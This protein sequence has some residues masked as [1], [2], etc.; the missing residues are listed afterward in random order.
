MK[1][2]RRLLVAGLLAVVLMVQL[3]VPVM[4]DPNLIAENEYLRNRVSHM[5][6]TIARLN[7]ELEDR[8]DSTPPPPQNPM[9][10]LVNPSSIVVMPGEALDVSITVRNIGTGTAFNIL[11]QAGA[12][13]APFTVEFRNNTNTVGSM[14]QNG[15]RQMNLRITV[16]ENAEPGT[17]HTITLNHHFR[18]NAGI[19]S[20]SQDT[21]NVRVGGEAGASNVRLGNIQT[22]VSTVGPG[23]TFV[24]T[25]DVENTGT[26]SANN[27]QV[28]VGNLGADTI[29]LTS[30]LSQAFF[31]TLDAGQSRQVSFTF[32]T[33]RN[34]PSSVHRLDFNL[35]YEDS[36][37]RAA[38]PFFVTV[39][40]DY[41]EE[42]ANIEMRGLTAPTGRLNVSQ[43]GNITFEL[44]NTGDAAAQSILVTATASDTT[45]LVP[46]TSNRQTVQ[47]LDIGATR[48]FTFGFMPTESARTQSHTVQ[49]R[50][51]YTMRGADTSSSFVQYIALNVYNPEAQAEPTPQPGTQIPRMIVSAYTPTPQIP[52]AGQNFELEISFLNTSMTRAI[53]NI[54]ITLNSSDA[55]G[56]TGQ[57]V[58]GAVFT[59]VGGSNTLF[60]GE[61]DPGEDITKNITMFTVPDASPRVY[62]LDVVFDFQD[63]NYAVHTMTERLS[64]PVAQLSRIEMHPPQPFIPEF[65]D[66]FSFIEFEFSVINTGRVNL[67]NTWV[68]VEG[69][70]DTSESDIFMATLAAQRTH[71]Y[72]G[73]VRPLEAGLLEG[74]IIIYGE[75][76]VGAVTELRHEFTVYVS[77]GGGFGGDFGGDFGMGMGGDRFPGGF[78]GDEGMFEG[79]GFDRPGFG[80]WPYEDG[81]GDGIIA[82]VNAFV[83]RP[84]FWGPAAGVVAVAVIAII[85]IVKRKKSKLSFDD[86]SAFN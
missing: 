34:I 70:F 48:A 52:R 54:R 49:L 56:P 72:T 35:T 20:S 4:A 80:M 16:D 76:D 59:P 40:S 7:R 85:V 28:S 86:D 78:P 77:D 21:I 61:L 33:A 32:Q 41:A 63:E 12:G 42:S 39:L 53:N 75:D 74:A 65:M 9:I 26:I 79:G 18:N 82:R 47:S 50:V 83:R 36:G 62:T 67:R 51:E 2:F 66:M 37:V 27:L 17:T 10:R 64:I 58:S 45:A 8:P 46:T 22:S 29:F 24:I 81:D 15:T 73:R 3:A 38:I 31:T 60:I 68:R 1:R 71:W 6:E 55:V 30:D 84:V 14:N 57:I 23:Q 19:N 69:P 13:A 43:T 44:V 11:T 25:A 5:E